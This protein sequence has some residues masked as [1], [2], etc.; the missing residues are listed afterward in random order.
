MRWWLCQGNN[1]SSEETSG[2]SP[3][4]T[5][6]TTSDQVPPTSSG[7]R[8]LAMTGAVEWLGVCWATML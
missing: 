1:P 7:S 8:A 4:P 6:T 2:G 5:P 3:T